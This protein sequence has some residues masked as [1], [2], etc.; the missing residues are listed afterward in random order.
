MAN[1]KNIDDLRDEML[2]VFEKLSKGKIELEEASIM[3]KISETIVSGAKTQ[4]Q[5]A[6]LTE[7]KIIIPFLEGNSK[8][9]ERK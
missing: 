5:Y 3:A 4:I 6:L 1:I 2:L 7:T 8:M 9:I